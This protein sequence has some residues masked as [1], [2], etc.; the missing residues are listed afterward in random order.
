VTPLD[1]VYQ[2]HKLFKYN[3]HKIPLLQ[4]AKCLSHN[5]EF[6]L[7]TSEDE[8]V[9]GKL[10]DEVEKCQSHLLEN[11]SCKLLGDKNER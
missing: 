11:P 3:H 8:F 1:L 10:H 2:F 9:S 4:L 7:P 6:Q 5:L